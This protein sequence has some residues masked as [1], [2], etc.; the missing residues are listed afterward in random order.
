MKVLVEQV[1]S[2]GRKFR[3]SCL[4][5]NAD[6]ISITSQAKIPPGEGIVSLVYRGIQ[7]QE[8][9]AEQ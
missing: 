3:H 5:Q 2:L 8:N 4:A 1:V 7:S 6:N 9:H